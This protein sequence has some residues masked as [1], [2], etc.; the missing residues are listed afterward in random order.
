MTLQ[1]EIL[2]TV[3]SDCLKQMIILKSFNPIA[4]R[5]AKIVNNFGLS[6][7]NGVNSIF[8]KISK[9]IL[10]SFNSVFRLLDVVH[11]E[12]KLYLV[13]EYLHQD[14]KKY[15]DNCPPTGLGAPLIKVKFFCH[16]VSDK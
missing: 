11:S 16:A 9:Q 10:K 13:F 7:C 4:L 5:K 3:T 6:E 12:K 1:T 2:S 8:N 15:M 14:L